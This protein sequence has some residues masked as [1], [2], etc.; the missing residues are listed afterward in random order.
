MTE[1]ERNELSLADMEYL[2]NSAMKIMEA[3][4]TQN[5][6]EPPKNMSVEAFCYE[7]AEN[8]LEERKRRYPKFNR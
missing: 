8:M 4:Y 7:T 2:D 3:F 6:C 5:E 1:Q